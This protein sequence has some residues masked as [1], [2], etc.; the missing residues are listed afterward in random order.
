MA[1]ASVPRYLTLRLSAQTDEEASLGMTCV[2][3]RTG[4]RD[5]RACSLSR[6]C[7]LL[8]RSHSI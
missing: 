7:S 3:R 5:V 8:F 2:G 6:H 4:E 1:L